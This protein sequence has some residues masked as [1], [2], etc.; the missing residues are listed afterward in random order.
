[1]FFDNNYTKYGLLFWPFP[2]S[3]VAVLA[4]T[5][6]PDMVD[7]ALLRPGRIDRSVECPLPPD[8]AARLSILR[9]LSSRLSVLLLPE[10]EDALESIAQR[11]AG[12]TGADLQAVLFNAQL[13]ALQRNTRF[14]SNP[15]NS[16]TLEPDSNVDEECNAMKVSGEASSNKP[17][18][19][20]KERQDFKNIAYA[21][22]L[23][24]G[25][26]EVRTI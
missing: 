9:V 25:F 1:M 5:S 4:A 15:V 3:G 26:I 23:S 2:A 14:G 17:N 12:F 16:I 19:S 7:P 21:P 18:A 10:A 20:S 22:T 8:V 13:A 11:T 6:R 24:K